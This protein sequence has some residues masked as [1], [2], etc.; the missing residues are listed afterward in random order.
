MPYEQ[1]PVNLYGDT[2]TVEYA[3]RDLKREKI[4]NDLKLSTK[5]CQALN[6]CTRTATTSYKNSQG[7]TMHLCETCNNKRIE[8]IKKAK[9]K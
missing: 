9:R 5:T 4:M 1:V 8:A 6:G 7:R 2:R 3:V